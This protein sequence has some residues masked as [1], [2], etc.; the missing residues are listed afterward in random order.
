MDFFEFMAYTQERADIESKCTM[1]VENDPY[2]TN[3]EKCSS[4]DSC[5]NFR[6]TPGKPVKYDN[7]NCNERESCGSFKYTNLR[8]ENEVMEGCVIS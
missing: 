2:Y 8:G 6:A 4:M 1:K 5:Y 7:E 3:I